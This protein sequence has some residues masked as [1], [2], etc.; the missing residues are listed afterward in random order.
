MEEAKTMETPMSSSIKLDKNEKSKSIDSTMYKGMIADFLDSGASFYSR[1]TYGIGGLIISIIRGVEI[2]LDPES[3]CRIFYIALVGLRVLTMIS[4][5][6]HH[7]IC[8]IMLPRGGHR[9][10]ISY[11][12]AFLMKS[13][14]TRRW[15]HTPDGSWVKRAERPPA[16]ARGQGEAHPGVE[17]E[18]KIREMDN[19]PSFIE[20]PYTETPSHQAPHAPDHAPWMDLSAHISSLD[21]RMDELVV[22]NDT[23]FYSMEDHIDQYQ[24]GFTSQFEYLQQ[25]FERMKNRMDQQQTSFTSWL[26]S[27]EALMDQHQ[28]LFGHLQ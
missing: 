11:Y 17:E 13:I 3:I 10:E 8:S 2:C 12:E 20:P 26:E 22:V 7:M 4:R 14:L 25:R 16:Q 18:A 1:A 23:Q 9:D 24:I 5:V 15:I 27:L 6:L 21:T 28:T 19:G